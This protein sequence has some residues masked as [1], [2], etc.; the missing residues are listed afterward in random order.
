VT[1][2][3]SAR[4]KLRLRLTDVSALTGINIALLSQIERGLR[5]PTPRQRALLA[6]LFGTHN[7]FVSGGNRTMNAPQM[8]EMRW[9]D[10]GTPDFSH[11]DGEAG[12]GSMREQLQALVLNP[13]YLDVEGGDSLAVR[14]IYPDSFVYEVAKD[15]STTVY[16]R[17]YTL[18]DG[19]TALDG[20]AEP[21][22]PEQYSVLS[23]RRL[24]RQGVPPMPTGQDN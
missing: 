16:R 6:N 14:E 24:P 18:E 21:V 19:Q 5:A 23:R 12:H 7:E 13:L 3:C 22:S 11:L 2:L 17:G 9:N 8:P 1:D 4:Q 15:G 10:D 20:D